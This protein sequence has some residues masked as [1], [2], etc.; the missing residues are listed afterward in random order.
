[1]PVDGRGGRYRMHSRGWLP[2]TL[3]WDLHPTEKDPPRRLALEATGD[4]VGTG[5][6]TL[7]ADPPFTD[8]TYDWRIRADKLLLK[9]L[10]FLMKPL[11]RWNHAWAMAGGGESVKRELVGR[12]KTK[13]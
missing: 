7:S 12:R 5:V 6:W 11:F 10:S 13:K 9:Y 1:P 2:Y 3:R 8:I 4:F